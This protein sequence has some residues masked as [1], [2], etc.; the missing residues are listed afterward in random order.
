MVEFG[1]EPQNHVVWKS[2]CLEGTIFKS[3]KN[4]GKT[5]LAAAAAKSS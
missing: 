3:R 1:L 4:G 2:M 5:E